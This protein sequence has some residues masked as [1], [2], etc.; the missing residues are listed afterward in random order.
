MVP[1]TG[2]LPNFTMPDSIVSLLIST[3]ILLVTIIVLRG[4]VVRFIRRNVF[5]T[6]LRRKWLVNSR[7]GLLL[8]LLLGLVLIWGNELRALALSVVAIAIAFVVATKELILCLTGSLI[9][10]SSGA[11]NLGDRIQI[12]DF[13]GDVIDHN[14]LTTTILEVGPGKTMHQRSG[15]MITIPNALLVSE[16]VTRES[17]TEKFAFHT[18]SVPFKREDDWP[19]ARRAFQEAAGRHCSSYLEQGR[20]HMDR[21]SARWG[22]GLPPVEPRVSIHVP[23]AGEVHLVIRLPVPIGQRHAIEQAILDEVL[24]GKDYSKRTEDADDP[25]TS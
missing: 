22:L 18:F 6:D 19:A 15:R 12:K 5:A 20:E 21:V 11:F 17:F 10:S 9:K 3:L 25:E 24:S 16:A 14:L 4:L 2:S 7:N 8:L 13:R 1:D 23:S